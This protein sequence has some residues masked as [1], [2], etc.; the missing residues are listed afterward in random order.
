MSIS[1]VIESP[2]ASIHGRFAAIP[3]TAAIAMGRR[4]PTGKRK[5]SE[6]DRAAHNAAPLDF[7]DPGTFDGDRQCG[8]SRRD[9]SPAVAKRQPHVFD[10]RVQPTAR[11]NISSHSDRVID[12]HSA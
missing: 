6:L 5:A 11:R 10:R 9:V 2:H 8:Q 12:A 1:R 4:G 3:A 7:D